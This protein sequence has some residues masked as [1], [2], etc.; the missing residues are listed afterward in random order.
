MKQPIV[1]FREAALLQQ[2]EC[3]QQDQE[4]PWV[5]ELKC[6][7]LQPVRYQPPFSNRPWVMTQAGRTAMLGYLLACKKWALP[8]LQQ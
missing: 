1:G 6:G 8:V 5:A 4:Q 2:D 3:V 7:H